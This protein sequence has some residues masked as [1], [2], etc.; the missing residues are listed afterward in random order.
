MIHYDLQCAAGHAF[1]G[2]FKDSA[3]FDTQ[4]A[5]GFVTCPSC[6]SASVSRALM[7]PALGRGT[8]KFPKAAPADAKPEASPGEAVQPASGSAMKLV[9]DQGLPDTVRALLQRLRAE[10]ERSCDY[11]GDDFAEE[12]RRIHYGEAETRGIYGQATS[13]EAEALAEEGIDV[14]VLPWLPRTDS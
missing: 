2:W 14:G 11:V 9:A 4:A 1:D 13:A 10:V 7:A 3:S 5:A 12:A 8:G 6:N